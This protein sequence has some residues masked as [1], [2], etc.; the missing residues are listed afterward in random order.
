MGNA[1]SIIDMKIETCSKKKEI[2]RKPLHKQEQEK[3]VQL[4]PK[5]SGKNS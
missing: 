5:I 1:V 2:Q 4:C 3:S